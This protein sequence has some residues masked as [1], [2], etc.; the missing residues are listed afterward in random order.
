MTLKD[1]LL[2]LRLDLWDFDYANKYLKNKTPR[3]HL[4][5]HSYRGV[6]ECHVYLLRVI[7]FLGVVQP[8]FPVYLSFI[9][10]Y[11]NCSIELVWPTFFP[12]KF[13]FVSF[14]QLFPICSNLVILFSPSVFTSNL[15]PFL[16]WPLSFF[17]LNFFFE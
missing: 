12:F 7:R 4:K 5:V 11:F 3:R 13:V 15:S 16:L 9:V 2:S 8:I 6:R 14:V 10:T 1:S 17:P